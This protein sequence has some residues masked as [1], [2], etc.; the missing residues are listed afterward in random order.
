MPATAAG[1]TEAMRLLSH[2]QEGEEAFQCA[3]HG[4][5]AHRSA[6]AAEPAGFRDDFLSKSK[7][8]TNGAHRL[9]RRAS[10]WAGDSGHRHR[11]IATA[12][13]QRAARHLACRLL[14]DRA[15]FFQGLLF[16]AEKFP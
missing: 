16:H 6:I 11:D 4:L 7:R 8:K 14:A 3:D 15:V 2:R 1:R 13:P 12:A 10:S 9:F 5:A